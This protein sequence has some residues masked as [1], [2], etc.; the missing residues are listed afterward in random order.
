M[1]E[2]LVKIQVQRDIIGKFPKNLIE[3]VVIFSSVLI[4]LYLFNNF[5]FDFNDIIL[6][7]S[8]FLIIAYKIIPSL[9][10]IYYNLNIVKNHLP[11]VN[12]LSKDL[13]NSQKKLKNQIK[14]HRVSKTLI[15]LKS[16]IFHLII[17]IIKTF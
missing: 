14:A 15:F 3:L 11:A 17:K 12:K 2:Q 9:Q 6:K 5:N 8:A 7:M 4:I 16:K 13:K 1:Y 10:Q